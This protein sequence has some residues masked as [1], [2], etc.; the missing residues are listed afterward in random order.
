MAKLLYS[1]TMSLDGFIAGPGGD[2]SWLTRFLGPNPTAEALVPRIG[3]ML[4]GNRTFGGDDPN[5]GTDKEG[6]MSG[7]WHGPVFV[8]THNPPPQPVPD[9]T[10]LS[11]LHEA[12]TAARKAAGD[13]YVNVLGADVARQALTA[14]L[15]DEILVF[16]APVLLGDGTRLYDL[17]GGA[18][19]TLERLSSA[20]SPLANALWFSVV[21]DH[22]RADR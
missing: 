17:P 4:V 13:R 16:V 7:A 19:V 10:F 8:L 5:R 3:A 20:E 1:V 2:M 6:A 9:V 21:S 14:G 22:G 18:E 12:V 15:L 11:D